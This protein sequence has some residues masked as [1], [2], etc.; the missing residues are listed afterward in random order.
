MIK[1]CEYMIRN[2]LG[3]ER[4]C[5]K[6]AR[7]VNNVPGYLFLCRSHHIQLDGQIKNLE[8]WNEEHK[9]TVKRMCSYCGKEI[10]LRGYRLRSFR[11]FCNNSCRARFYYRF[12]LGQKQRQ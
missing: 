3:D 7:M 11:N 5:G 8:K 4:Y 1:F 9:N 10:L 2:E 6:P 12:H